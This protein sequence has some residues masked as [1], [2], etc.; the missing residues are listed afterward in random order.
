MS[1]TVKAVANACCFLFAHV[2]FDS[3]VCTAIRSIRFRE[4]CSCAVNC[5]FDA[6]DSS[7][8]KRKTE[9]QLDSISLSYLAVDLL[10]LCMPKNIPDIW[11]LLKN[12]KTSLFLQK[13][14][15]STRIDFIV[16]LSIH[17]VCAHLNHFSFIIITKEIC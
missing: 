16:L 13:T 17:S 9:K 2:L 1:T 14:K 11:R 4:Y 8:K 10:L 7:I 6:V 15:S 12:A 5:T 3:V